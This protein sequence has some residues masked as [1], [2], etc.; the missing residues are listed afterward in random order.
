MDTLPNEAPPDSEEP[1]WR[2]PSPMRQ[3]GGGLPIAE[4]APRI[5]RA[6]R[7]FNGMTASAGDDAPPPAPS[8]PSPP[9]AARGRERSI[10]DLLLETTDEPPET[11]LKAGLRS[12]W[13][14]LRRPDDEGGATDAG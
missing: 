13:R 9:P 2:L 4:S 12:A 5:P 14:R 8:P 10:R 11:G 6:L 3:Q 7:A 1:H